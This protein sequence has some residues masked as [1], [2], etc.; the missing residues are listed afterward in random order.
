MKKR[1]ENSEETNIAKDIVAKKKSTKKITQ[2][3]E[4]QNK[5]LPK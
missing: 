1:N 3:T 2:K 5:L 4:L